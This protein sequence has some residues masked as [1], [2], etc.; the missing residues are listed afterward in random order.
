MKIFSILV[1]VF[2]LVFSGVGAQ[3]SWNLSR[4]ISFAME[5]NLDLKH[6]QLAFEEQKV[7][8]ARSRNERLP[9]IYANVGFNE[10]FG[11]SVDPA[12][13]DYANVN[14]FNNT[15]GVGLSMALFQGF[16]RSSRIAFEKHNFLAAKTNVEHQKNL[17][18]Y[19]V[20]EAYY[21]AVLQQGLLKIAQENLELG[22]KQLFNIQKLIE[23]GRKAESDIYEIQAKV[24]TDSFL[25]VRQKGFLEKSLSALKQAMH[26]PL[27]DTLT[28]DTFMISFVSL[29][30]LTN[31]DMLKATVEN[32]ALKTS[33]QKLIAAKKLVNEA[34]GNFSPSLTL[35]AGWQTNYTAAANETNVPFRDQFKNHAGEYVGVSLSIPLFSKFEKYTGLR[36]AKLLYKKAQVERDKVL[37]NVQSEIAN[38]IIDWQTSRNELYAAQRQ[39]EKSLVAY[40]TAEKK[41]FIGQLNVIEYDIQ[42]AELFK[43]RT[44]LLRTSLQQVQQE[45]YLQ[46]IITGKWEIN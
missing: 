36:Q 44:E 2:A 14:F 15:Y 33:E 8:L 10:R 4:C 17:L 28:V 45:K 40:Q 6:Q 22:N 13:N 20:M 41:L 12:T 7:N 3:Q 30:S 5:N 32:L 19:S 35:N 23:T 1:I 38:A 39:F 29:D 25:L 24:A 11:R 27:T 18:V 46:F 37:S 34:R 26:Y 9:E 21:L 43:S 16:V 31:F 42:K